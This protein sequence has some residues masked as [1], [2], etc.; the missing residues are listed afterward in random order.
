MKLC[1]DKILSGLTSVCFSSESLTQDAKGSHEK[2]SVPQEAGKSVRHDT[3]LSTRDNFHSPSFNL[4]S[5]KMKKHNGKSV[6]KSAEK[7][8]QYLKG[9]SVIVLF[10]IHQRI[11]F[12]SVCWVSWSSYLKVLKDIRQMV[13][14]HQQCWKTPRC[15]AAADSTVADTRT[16]V[17]ELPG[18]NTG[19]P[20]A[21]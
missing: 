2:P 18:W 21:H 7:T 5:Q 8:F 15:S 9:F 14:V 11:G 10:E 12:S 20:E 19:G 1:G 4:V 16:G 13:A 6:S 3:I 17:M